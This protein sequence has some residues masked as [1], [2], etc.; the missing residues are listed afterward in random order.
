MAEMMP[1]SL[2]EVR[3]AETSH[4]QY[5]LGWQRATIECT[6]AWQAR[7]GSEPA[8]RDTWSAAAAEHPRLQLA[9]GAL[10]LPARLDRSGAC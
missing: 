6:A 8:L 3:Q 10:G 7:S 5:A 1:V 9:C 2:D 4:V